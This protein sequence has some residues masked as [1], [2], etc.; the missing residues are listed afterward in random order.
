MFPAVMVSPDGLIEA[1]YDEKAARRRVTTGAACSRAPVR[2]SEHSPQR[3]RRRHDATEVACDTPRMTS[4]GQE[5]AEVVDD[6]RLLLTVVGRR[7]GDSE[8]RS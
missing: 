8:I 1:Y 2:S 7:A 4:R 3:Q 5:A 6:Q